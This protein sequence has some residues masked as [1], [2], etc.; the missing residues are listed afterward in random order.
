MRRDFP[1]GELLPFSS[2]AKRSGM[3]AYETWLLED[4]KAMLAYA[5]CAPL[6]AHGWVLVAYFAV[7][8]EHRSR[9]VGTQMLEQLQAMY[10]RRAGLLVEVERP[11]DAPDEAERALR[12]R[13]VAFYVQR[14]FTLLPDMGYSVF[15]VPMLLMAHRLNANWPPTELDAALR[16]IYRTI[17]GPAM[18]DDLS[19]GDGVAGYV[20]E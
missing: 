5:V 10:A 16:G 20:L 3:D 8:P 14:G 1:T 15:T 6:S 7:L 19:F 4:G 12:N 9:G 17:I 13:R 11:R 18:L 2:Y